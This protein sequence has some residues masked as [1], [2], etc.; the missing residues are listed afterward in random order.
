[1]DGTIHCDA[2]IAVARLIS[3][4]GCSLTQSTGPRACTAR[5][6][7]GASS[8]ASLAALAQLRHHPGLAQRGGYGSRA[9]PGSSNFITHHTQP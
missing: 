3:H 2:G 5:Q 4:R 6:S 8:I 1:M 7:L 9:D